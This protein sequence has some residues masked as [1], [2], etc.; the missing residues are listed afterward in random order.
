MV[1]SPL[2]AKFGIDGNTVAGVA[3][4]LASLGVL[5]YS[6]Y[7]HWNMKKGPETAVVVN[8]QGGA[9]S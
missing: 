7:N 6:I 1:L 2:A 8:Q 3:T 4:A 9:R 5:G